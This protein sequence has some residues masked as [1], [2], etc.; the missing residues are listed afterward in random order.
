M[1]D[2]KYE[3][4]GRKAP[5]R[6]KFEELL[7]YSGYYRTSAES[8]L[9]F[10]LLFGI[11]LSVIAFFI[12]FLVT[13]SLH[14]SV[15]SLVLVFLAFYGNPFI[16]LSLVSNRRSAEVNTILP[17]ALQLMA[18]N[19]RAGMTTER[20]IW[21]SARPEFGPLEDEIHRISSKVMGGEPLT[22][23]LDNISKNINSNLLDRAVKLMNEGIRS[24][25]EMAT[26]LD[27]TATDIRTA[28]NMR[29]K[30]KANV[31]MYSMFIVFASVL[32]AP[33]LFALSVY[34]IEVTSSLWVE[35]MVATE[36]F[37]DMGSGMMS[38]EG[39][40]IDPS[41]LKLFSIGAI[42]ITTF[43]G[44]MIIGLIQKG[45]SINGLKYSPLMMAAGLT[46][47]FI[48]NI[49]VTRVFGGFVGL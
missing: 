12:I 41:T 22:K 17:D 16:Y 33:L 31:T 48:A 23:A 10:L 32:G 1:I 24:G 27:E 15:L 28:Q 4:L 5:L 6:E 39:P 9:G 40:Q 3:F 34:F 13:G 20:A 11:S 37:G 18:A 14:H 29:E 35:E 8:L 46:V 44:G 19:I 36:G 7:R 25:G 43:F 30:V 49:L 42:S 21:L 47:F 45:K 26:L 38:M 2:I